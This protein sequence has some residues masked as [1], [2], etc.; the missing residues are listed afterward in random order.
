MCCGLHLH[1]TLDQEADHRMILLEGVAIVG[2][3]IVLEVEAV[4]DKDK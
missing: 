3:T 1:D 2:M 4:I